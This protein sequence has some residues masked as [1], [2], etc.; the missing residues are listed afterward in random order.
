MKKKKIQAGVGLAVL[1]ACLVGLL[2]VAFYGIGWQMKGSY[3]DIKL[4]LDLAGGVS[5]TYQAVEDETPSDEDMDDTVYKLQRRVEQYSTEAQVYREGTDRITIEIPG[6]SDANAILE[7]L[8]QPGQLYFIRQY[9][10]DGNANYSLNSSTYQYELASGKTIESLEESGDIIMTGTDV[11]DAQA[12]YQSDSMNNNEIVV[13]LTLT[14]EGKQKFADATTTAAAASPKQSIGIYYDGSFISVPTVNEAITNGQAVITGEST[15]EDAQNLAS[16]IRIGGLNV[17]LEELRSNVVGAQLGQS[18]ITASEKAGIVGFL[19]I[20]VFMCAVYFLPGLCA[21]LALL[22]YVGLMVEILVGFEITLTIS[23]IAGILL[24][25]GMAVDANVIVFARIREE[26]AAGHTVK[27][28]ISAGYNKA[29]SAILDGNITTLIAAAVLGILGSG[30]VRGFA[31]TLAIGILLSMFS[32]LAVTR[33]FMWAFYYLFAKSEK[34]YGVGKM[35][36]PV[37]FVEHRKIFFTL[38]ICV[39]LMGFVVMGVNHA[40]GNG[41]LNYSLDFVG[42][43]S[44]D[45]TFNED[46]T[47]DQ[48]DQDAVPIFEDITGNSNVQVQKVSG[49]NEVIFKSTAMDVDQRQ[50]LAGKLEDKYG[51]T[52]DAIKAETISSTISSE[53]QRDAFGAVLLALVLMLIYIWFRFKDMRFGAAAIIALAHDCLVVLTVYAVTRI[54]VGSTFIACMLTIVGY[55]INATIVIFDRVRE[56]L[57]KKKKDD[58]IVELVD[59]SIT[60]TLS[61]TIFSSLTTFFMVF[62]LFIFGGSSL[63]EFAVPIMSGIVAGT[64]SSVCITGSLWFVLRSH[65]KPKHDDSGV[66]QEKKRAADKE[67][68]KK[69]YEAEV[70]KKT[71]V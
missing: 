34:F 56:N 46:Y 1:L 71:T 8:G 41:A 33:W 20:V 2:Y 45:V 61:R 5:I 53:M 3:E 28:S 52:E 65:F 49:S 60:D 15:I 27:Q 4:G 47:L 64:Y 63:R 36:K 68:R 13:S 62:T 43:T 21:S 12:G 9:D 50:E 42:G 24:S 18:A 6:V 67:E 40:R 57:R 39:I 22:F 48:L 69:A 38:S 17:K 14:D 23:G 58:S 35:R 44:T 55:S 7:E 25:V 66:Y 26:L 10:D 51:I 70:R 16:A 37:H 29:L 32:A 59:K 54:S 30:T 31:A 19:M 11:S